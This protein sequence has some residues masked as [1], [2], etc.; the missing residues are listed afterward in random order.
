MFFDVRHVGS[1]ESIKESRG[2][3]DITHVRLGIVGEVISPDSRARDLM[4]KLNEYEQA[5]IPHYWIVDPEERSVREFV[6]DNETGRYEM[7]A[8]A[9]GV[10]TPRL[11][12]TNDPTFQLYLDRLFA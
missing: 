10:A 1:L 8:S 7:V 5:G 2:R 12:S 4:E 9:G 6:L 11:F 3:I